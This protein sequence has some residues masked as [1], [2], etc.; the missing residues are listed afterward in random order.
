[1]IA[2]SQLAERVQG[3]RAG[4]GRWTARCP[5]H[6]DR[7]ASL[8]IGTGRDGRP[9]VNCFAGC[10][11]KAILEVLGLSFADVLPERQADPAP[12]PAQGK[13]SE[14][15]TTPLPIHLSAGP[16]RMAEWHQERYR[17]ADAL[18]PLGISFLDDALD[19][20]Y[21]HDLLLIG[22][23][24]GAG[25]TALATAIAESTAR[26]GA[27]ADFI[28]LE[29]EPKEIEARILYRLVAE[30]HYQRRGGGFVGERGE[31]FT[32][33]NWKAGRLRPYCLELENAIWDEYRQIL[34]RVSVIYRDRWFDADSLRWCVEG[35]H[36]A[37]SKL[38]IL[39]HLHFLDYEEDNENRALRTVMQTLREL[40]IDFGTPIIACCQ[41][42]KRD[43]RGPKFPELEDIHGSSDI[44]KIATR[45][46]LIA[47]DRD[48]PLTDDK[49]ATLLQVVKDRVGGANPYVA[50][51]TYSLTTNRYLDHYELGRVTDDG[52]EPAMGTRPHWAKRAVMGEPKPASGRND[53]F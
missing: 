28:A 20:L 29:A 37:G 34:G 50:R 1:M 40:S 53:P 3:K 39:D 42:R 7:Q 33:R 18:I 16:D 6:E 26:R 9:L 17:A 41:L 36:R 43:R 13:S 31:R 5:A 11:A 48:T 15:P 51:C 8:S 52:F 23:P 47:P 45:V 14:S 21:P 49:R 32:Y 12:R 30:E 24:T 38:I 44:A 19:G 25:K 4:D 27:E 2:P 35:L 46:V 22:A 10:E